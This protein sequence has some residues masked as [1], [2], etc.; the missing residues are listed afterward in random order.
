MP[1][2][3]TFT[4]GADALYELSTEILPNKGDAVSPRGEDTFEIRGATIEITN[5]TDAL[6]T[7]MGRMQNL[8]LAALEAL[9]LIGGFSDPQLMKRASPPMARYMDGGV[10]TGAYGP[11][12]ASQMPTVLRRLE[13]DPDTRQAI[14]TIWDPV[15]DLFRQHKDLPC[16]VYLSFYIRN[17]QLQMHT[18]MRS[19]DI[20]LGWTYDV[21]QFTQ[22]QCTVANALDLYPGTYTHYVDSLHI[23][24]RDVEAARK[25]TKPESWNR[26][27]VT[28]IRYGYDWTDIQARAYNIAY[29][30]LGSDLITDD[31]DEW[32]SKRMESL[33][34][35]STQ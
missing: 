8:K 21:F 13:N 24:A 23:Y 12:I 26:D 33:W 15:Q 11:R 9:Q 25:L 32:Y 34:K 10:L 35:T 22:L 16:T 2:T 5:P 20:W 18:H 1:E 31:A 27:R 14:V 3:F 28:G 19:N 6:C 30:D 29:R 17:D 7:G 4:S